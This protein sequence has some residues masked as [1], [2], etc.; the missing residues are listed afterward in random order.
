MPYKNMYIVFVTREDDIARFDS[1]RYSTDEDFQRLVED[2]Q[3]GVVGGDSGG[4]VG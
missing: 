3:E 2:S 1:L 4:E